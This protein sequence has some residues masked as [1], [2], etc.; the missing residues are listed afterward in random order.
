MAQS[1]TTTL[2]RARGRARAALV[3]TCSCA[4][5]TSAPPAPT[6]R[7]TSGPRRPPRPRP[8][9]KPATSPVAK[10]ADQSRPP[11]RPSARSPA[12]RRARP[13]SPAAS[14]G[15]PSR[16]PGRGGGGLAQPTP[17]EHARAAPKPAGGRH[18]RPRPTGDRR[19]TSSRSPFRPTAR[20]CRAGGGTAQQGAPI[21]AAK[22][23]SC[24][25]DAGQG[26]GNGPQLVA[27]VPWQ[28]GGPITMGNFAPYAPPIF[29]YIWGSHALRQAADALSRRGVCAHRVDPGAAQDHRRDRPH[30]RAE[31]APG[32]RCRTRRTSYPAIRGPTYLSK[33]ARGRGAPRP[34]DRASTHRLTISRAPVASISRR[35]RTVDRID[36]VE[37]SSPR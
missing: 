36:Q 16:K 21:Y 33:H 24:H 27:P 31:P 17:A 7:A 30:G 8:A 22:C 5:C 3:A 32:A 18:R 2:R 34:A 4:G 35:E 14:P 20:A 26:T 25:G 9:A 29:G 10:P 13:R 19:R 28:V 37:S 15:E 12:R 11:V 1:R 23:A 6:P